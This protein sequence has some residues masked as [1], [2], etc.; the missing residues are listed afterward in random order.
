MFRFTTPSASRYPRRASGSG[1]CPVGSRINGDRKGWHPKVKARPLVDR[2]QPGDH[3][4]LSLDHSANYSL[5]WSDRG[6][7]ISTDLHVSPRGHPVRNG[8]N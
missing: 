8:C 7:A 4:G 5:A 2:P 1:I 6:A 3:P